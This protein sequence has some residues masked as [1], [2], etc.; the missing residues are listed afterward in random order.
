MSAHQSS[1]RHSSASHTR[2]ECKQVLAGNRSGVSMT[3]TDY[4]CSFNAKVSPVE[5]L[6]KIRRVSD[7]WTHAIEGKTQKLDDNFTVTFGE[8]FVTL[9]IVAEIP[10]KKLVWRVTDCNLHWIKDK[11]EWKGTEIVWEIAWDGEKSTVTMTHVGLA[12]EGECYQTC[13]RG[14]NFYVGESLRNLIVEGEGFPDMERAK[15]VITT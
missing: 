6:D 14:W 11:K 7:W 10:E 13:E 3:A 8:T 15:H 2:A 9:V 4:Q 5:A 12:P 1:A